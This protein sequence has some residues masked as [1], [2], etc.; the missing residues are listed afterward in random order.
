[1]AIIVAGKLTLKPGKRDEFIQK[2][3]QAISQA[4]TLNGCEDFSVSVDPIDENRVNIFEKWESRNQL[5]EFRDSGPDN[6]SFSL[7]EYFDV[8]EYEVNT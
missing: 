7:V 8:I 6:D 5:E 2:S 1:M 3:L 4:R